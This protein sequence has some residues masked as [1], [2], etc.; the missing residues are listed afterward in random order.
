[1]EN[2]II[3][4]LIIGAFIFFLFFFKY[5]FSKE[6]GSLRK[7]IAETISSSQNNLFTLQESINKSLGELYKNL[8]SIYESSRAVLEISRSFERVFRSPSPRGGIGETLLE[9]IIKELMP[10]SSFKFQYSF[11]DGRT[12]DA[13]LFFPQGLVAIDSKFPLES[14]E[15]YILSSE[16]KEK[17]RLKK[18]FF[19]AVRERIDEASKYILPQQNT[20]DFSFMYVP[21]ESIYYEIVNDPQTLEYAKS[22]RVFVVSPSTLYAYLTTAVL[23]FK[24]LKIEKEAK[25]ILEHIKELELDIEDLRKSFSILGS[26]LHNALAKYNEIFQKLQNISSKIAYEK[27]WEK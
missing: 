27:K 3:I 23:G 26:H 7:E 13:V 12:A 10:P 18:K 15:N 8:G 6:L 17:E 21:S 25:K 24:G 5:L 22:K 11:E 4:L 20:F 16:E 2:L 9:N 1:M 14:F 19:S